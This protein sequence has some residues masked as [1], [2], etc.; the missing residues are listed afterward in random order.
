MNRVEVH[1]DKDEFREQIVRARDD[2]ERTV[3][4]IER[5]GV[6][7]HIDQDEDEQKMKTLDYVLKVYDNHFG[8]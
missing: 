6:D 8:G 5:Y 4:D 1:P 3:K 2:A 7:I